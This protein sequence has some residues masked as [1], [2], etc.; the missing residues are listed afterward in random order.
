MI[1]F[2]YDFFQSLSK[3]CNHAQWTDVG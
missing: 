2:N 1:V 3:R